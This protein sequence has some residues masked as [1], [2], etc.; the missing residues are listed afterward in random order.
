MKQNR[1]T[2]VQQFTTH[3]NEVTTNKLKPSLESLSYKLKL[4]KEMKLKELWSIH[5]INV[6]FEIVQKI[7]KHFY[8]R[9]KNISNILTVKKNNDFIC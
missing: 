4:H 9:N 5:D 1:T 2:R 8:N 7:C 3:A 6:D